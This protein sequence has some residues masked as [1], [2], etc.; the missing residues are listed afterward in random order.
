MPAYPADHFVFFWQP[1]SPFSQWTYSEFEV[2]GVQYTHGEQFMMA[3][4]ARL[5]GD[6]EHRTSILAAAHPREQKRLGRQVRGFSS[7]RWIA[8]R[9]EIVQRGNLAKFSQDEELLAAL[10]ATGERV[11]AE[12]SPSDRIWGIGLKDSDPR[13][14]DPAQW[15]GQNLLGNVLMRVRE[16]LRGSARGESQ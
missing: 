3:E 9:L 12:A 5:F 11:L 15:P 16:I 13:A 7:K 10:L 8:A 4:K 1:P 6:E 14:L 2:D